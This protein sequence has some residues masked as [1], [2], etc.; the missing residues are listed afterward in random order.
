MFV[1][2]VYELMNNNKKY[3]NYRKLSFVRANDFS[4]ESNKTKLKELIEKIN[5]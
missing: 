2:K 4:M 1:E 3:E 5:S